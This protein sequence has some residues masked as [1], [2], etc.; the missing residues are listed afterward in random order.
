MQ[1]GQTLTRMLEQGHRYRTSSYCEEYLAG[2]PKIYVWRQ[3]VYIVQPT[4]FSL[5]RSTAPGKQ[6][7]LCCTGVRKRPDPGL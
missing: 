1:T 2:Q 5:A 3:G 4:Y 6:G 7:L